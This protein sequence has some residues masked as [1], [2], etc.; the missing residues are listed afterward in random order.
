M[1]PWDIYGARLIMR[2]AV[3]TALVVGSLLNGV[4]HGTAILDGSVPWGHFILNY[5]IPF[6]VAT[7]SGLKALP[8]KKCE[9]CKPL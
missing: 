6:Y 5:L 9:S 7:Y 8:N 4:N 2:N 1:P 3:V